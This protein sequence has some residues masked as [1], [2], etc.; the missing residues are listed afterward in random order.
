MA[1]N[2]GT[3]MNGVRIKKVAVEKLGLRGGVNTDRSLCMT[4][5]LLCV[6]KMWL[7]HENTLLHDERRHGSRLQREF[8]KCTLAVASRC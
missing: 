6:S 2:V 4:C 7:E 5:Q 8:R 1:M 3:E